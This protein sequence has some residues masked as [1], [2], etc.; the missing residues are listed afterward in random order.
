M[1]NLQNKTLSYSP[2]R[3]NKTLFPLV[4]NTY[5]YDVERWKTVSERVE[6]VLK[7]AETQMQLNGIEIILEMLKE[8]MIY[9]R[10]ILESFKDIKLAYVNDENVRFLAQVNSEDIFTHL[11]SILAEYLAN[12]EKY[13]IQLGYRLLTSQEC[14]CWLRLLV[15]DAAAIRE[16]HPTFL[17]RFSK[18]FLKKTAE[19]RIEVGYIEAN[20]MKLISE[21]GD[22]M[23]R[24]K[25]AS[26]GLKAYF[27]NAHSNILDDVHNLQ[28][29]VEQFTNL[30]NETKF[31]NKVS[32]HFFRSYHTFDKVQLL[33]Q[34]INTH[35][36]KATKIF[37]GTCNLLDKN[38]EN[39]LSYSW[40]K[41]K[42]SV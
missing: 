39:T 19:L 20:V 14:S 25:T 9:Y 31:K 16:L 4:T 36:M 38:S 33:L 28:T 7:N 42:L 37:N 15:N 1:M 2:S 30:K 13:E 6:N 34:G 24:S 35:M 40:R 23:E 21:L 12:L 5:I 29:L 27:L 10:N 18:M 22:Y 32:G 3:F 41:M 8:I 17:K 11:K 26:D